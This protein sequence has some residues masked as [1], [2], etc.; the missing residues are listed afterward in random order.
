MLLFPRI[1]IHPEQEGLQGLGKE[2][3]KM[4]IFWFFSL[5]FLQAI[6][7]L[8]YPSVLLKTSHF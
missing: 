5:F 3:S 6:H 2:S 7:L 1:W 4:E 8:E